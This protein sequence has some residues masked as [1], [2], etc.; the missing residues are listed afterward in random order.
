MLALLLTNQAQSQD[1]WFPFSNIPPLGFVVQ[2]GVQNLSID[3]DQ[4]YLMSVRGGVTYLENYSTGISFKFSTNRINPIGNNDPDVFL[5][6]ALTALYVE[7]TFKPQSRLHITIP[8]D[9]GGGDLNYEFKNW[10][11]GQ[12]TFPYSEK[13]FFF[14]EPALQLEYNITSKLRCNLGASYV[15]IPRLQYRS[16]THQNTG[17]LSFGLGIKYGKFL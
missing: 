6:F 7:Y 11:P 17:P 16:V 12:N 10:Q 9:I 14:A 3:G 4:A 15:Y 1:K 5:N 13:Y 8:I 2:G